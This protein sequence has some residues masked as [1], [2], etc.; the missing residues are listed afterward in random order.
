MANTN[1]LGLLMIG[2]LMLA[3]CGSK[4]NN[5]DIIAPKPI[6]KHSDKILMMQNYKNTTNQNWAGST[7]IVSLSRTVDK[8]LSTAEDENGQKYYDNKIDLVVSRSDGSVFFKKTFYKTD[9]KQYIDDGVSKKGALLGVVFD[10]VDGQNLIFGASIG[11]PDKISDEFIPL[12]VKLSKTGVLSIS[13][14]TDLD[15]ESDIATDEQDDSN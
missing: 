3:S 13:K 15:T 5:G 6:E 12:V 14:D 1:V 8:S 11:S 9:F 7:Y 4:K 2:V 10:R